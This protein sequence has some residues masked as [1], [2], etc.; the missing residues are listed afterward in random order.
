MKEEHFSNVD[1][2]IVNAWLVDVM[3]TFKV[4]IALTQLIATHIYIV[5]RQIKHANMPYKLK[6]CAHRAI[7]VIWDMFASSIVI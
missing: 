2:D 3:A 5:T 6:A 1:L 4:K 7:S